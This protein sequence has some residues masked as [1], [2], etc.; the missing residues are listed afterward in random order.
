MTVETGSRIVGARPSMKLIT[1]TATETTPAAAKTVILRITVSPNANTRAADT[2]SRDWLTF[3]LRFQSVA[4]T[5]L[6]GAAFGGTFEQ[7]G[8]CSG[9]YT[10]A[11]TELRRRNSVGGFRTTAS[12]L[13][14][15]KSEMSCR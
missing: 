6:A 9:G 1:P 12:K 11:A 13:I 15:L 3:G 8:V 2:I 14:A 10:E 5:R 7:S 4:C